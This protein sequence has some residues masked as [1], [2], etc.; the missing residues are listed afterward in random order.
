MQKLITELFLELQDNILPFWMNK[1]VDKENGG[2]YGR[3]DGNSIVHPH[4]SK[5][6]ILNSRIL[7]SFSAMC[8]FHPKSEYQE[9]AYRSYG[10]LKKHFLDSIYGG[11]YWQV[12]YAGKPVDI[13]KQIYAQAFAIYGLSEYY[14]A[15]SI[16]KALELAIYLFE[17]IEKY[18]FD[19]QNNGYFEAFSQDWQLLDDMRLSDRDA[20]EIKSMNTHLHILEAYTNL[21]KI[22]PDILLKRQLINLIQ[23]FLEKIINPETYHFHLFFDEVWTVK[24]N[25]ISFGHDVEGS[26]LLQKAAETIGDQE[27]L[28]SIRKIVLKMVDVT[29]KEGFAG[30]GSIY[31]EKHDNQVDTDR[32]WWPQ[33]EALVALINAWQI[34]NDEKYLKKALKTWQFIRKKMVDHQNGEWFYKVNK[35]GKV[36]KEEDKAGFWKCPYHNTRAC[37]EVI[38]RLQSGQLDTIGKEPVNNY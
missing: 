30:D 7:W 16:P 32:H 33:A 31:Y 25:T 27:L 3:I 9:M 18:S 34:T 23:I 21:Y 20:N 13:K 8:K 29:L 22:W 4:A 1:M 35:R 19:S 28:R 6:L 24:S 17:K 12:D 26:W 2:F 15:F 10:Y 37:I 5:G 36:D 38:N 11:M 14:Q